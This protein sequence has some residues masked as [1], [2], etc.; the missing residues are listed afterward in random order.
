MGQAV[1]QAGWFTAYAKQDA[2]EL[3]RY[4]GGARVRIQVPVEALL[5]G[6]A[7]EK[8]F[9]LRPADLIFVPESIW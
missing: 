5:E 4:E 9:V 7:D 2:V 3:H 8:D 1:A 6:E